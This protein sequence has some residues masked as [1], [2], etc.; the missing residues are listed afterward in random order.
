MS[1][2][3][4]SA[5]VQVLIALVPMITALAAYLRSRNTAHKVRRREDWYDGI[6]EEL[7][8]K[9]VEH[10]RRLDQVESLVDSSVDPP[11]R[12]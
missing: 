2:E 8:N 12:R 10:D 9:A 5:L 11:V 7:N 1:Q 3:L 6:L 4:Q